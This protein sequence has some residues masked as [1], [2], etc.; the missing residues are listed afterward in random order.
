MEGGDVTVKVALA[1]ADPLVALTRVWPAV[2]DVG[3]ENVVEKVPVEVA[4]AAA[5]FV[6]PNV[7]WTVELA[8]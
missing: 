4:V 3:T 6:L 2:A 1:A 7:T 5:T 8:G